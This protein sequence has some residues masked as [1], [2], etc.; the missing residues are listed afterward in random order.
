MENLVVRIG[1]LVVVE[2]E[3]SQ[4]EEGEVIAKA[5]AELVVISPW[6]EIKVMFLQIK[7]GKG[8]IKG[9]QEVI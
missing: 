2:V 9:L 5:E 4:E 3:A 1:M 8:L 7:V 6:K